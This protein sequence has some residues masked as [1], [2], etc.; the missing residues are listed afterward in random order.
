MIERWSGV[1]DTC[2]AL[3]MPTHELT[4]AANMNFLGKLGLVYGT[5]ADKTA[6]PL[7]EDLPA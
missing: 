3:G 6:I 2:D 4:R 1:Q 5:M 7:A